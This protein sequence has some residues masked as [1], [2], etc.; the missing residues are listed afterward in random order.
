MDNVQSQPHL[1]SIGAAGEALIISAKHLANFGAGN[2]YELEQ[3]VCSYQANNN[4][5]KCGVPNFWCGELRTQSK[6]T[7]SMT[8][9]LSYSPTLCRE[10]VEPT[11]L[12]VIPKS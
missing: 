1:I 3:K 4:L 7:K 8:F 9:A 12:V 6:R 10:F 5:N 2:N 11:F